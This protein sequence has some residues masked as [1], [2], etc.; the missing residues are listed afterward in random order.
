MSVPLLLLLDPLADH[1][2]GRSQDTV[3]ICWFFSLFFSMTYQ[4]NIIQACYRPP[5]AS[6][7]VYPSLSPS[8]ATVCLLDEH[9]CSN[10]QCVFMV[11]PDSH[12]QIP[13]SKRPRVLFKVPVPQV[14]LPALMPKNEC[15]ILFSMTSPGSMVFGH[16]VT[17]ALARR[18]L[19]DSHILA[20]WDERFKW[21]T[22]YVWHFSWPGYDMRKIIAFSLKNAGIHM[23]EDLVFFL[24]SHIK[25][26]ILECMKGAL[27]GAGTDLNWAITE[28]HTLDDF[29]ISSF[30][31]LE[32]DMWC[33]MVTMKQDIADE[34]SFCLE[35]AVVEVAVEKETKRKAS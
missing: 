2:L 14:D 28:D 8:E 31:M 35:R 33:V 13:E 19:A 6:N 5:L 24:A 9:T 22:E 18:H 29:G 7:P 11:K 30:W 12:L 21:R 25:T 3:P 1:S 15:T 17:D 26:F 4:L 27:K 23:H 34:Y 10:Q 20:S 32:N 16:L